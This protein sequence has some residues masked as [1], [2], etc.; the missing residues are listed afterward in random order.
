MEEYYDALIQELRVRRSNIESLIDDLNERI[1]ERKS[2]LKRIDAIIKLATNEP[3]KPRTKTSNSANGTGSRS[4]PEVLAFMQEHKDEQEDWT[5]K[6]IASAMN[7]NVSSIN[8]ALNWLRENEKIRAT[9]RVQG[10]GNAY[11]PW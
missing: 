8:A 2:E 5:A 3:A 4:A 7:K 6:Q 1:K 9:R 11:A 10:G